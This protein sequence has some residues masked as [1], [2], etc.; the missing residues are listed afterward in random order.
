MNKIAF[1][2][3]DASMK[4]KPLMKS[5]EERVLEIMKCMQ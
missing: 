2:M 3:L 5:N 1:Y 4:F